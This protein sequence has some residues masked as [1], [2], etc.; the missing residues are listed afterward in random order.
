MDED[1]LA[2]VRQRFEADSGREQTASPSALFVWELSPGRVEL[3]GWTCERV[4]QR[5]PSANAT[6]SL[7]AEAAA[8]AGVS[9]VTIPAVSQCPWRSAAHPGVLLKADLFECASRGQAGEILLRLLGEFESPLMAPKRQAPG[10]IAFGGR[11][12][13]LLLFTRGNLVCLCRN[14][15]RVIASVMPMAAAL[16]RAAVG[17]SAGARRRRVAAAP[18][19]RDADEREGEVEVVLLEAAVTRRADAEVRRFAAPSGDIVLEGGRIVYRGP[20]AAARRIE[21]EEGL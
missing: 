16:D 8:S 14:A 12:D 17:G 9:P 4:R 21:I 2:M 10:D 5:L 1:W 3:P 18:H 6:G 19:P 13:G 20:A 11:G 7:R 15:E